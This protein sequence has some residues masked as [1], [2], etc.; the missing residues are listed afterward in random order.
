M[1]LLRTNFALSTLNFSFSFR[2]FIFYGYDLSPI[3]SSLLQSATIVA[4]NIAYVTI[5]TKLNNYENH[6]TVRP[7]LLDYIVISWCK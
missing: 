5:A 6:R 2:Y 4:L 1:F 3:I 7:A